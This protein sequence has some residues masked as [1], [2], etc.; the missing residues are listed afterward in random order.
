MIR[1][2]ATTKRKLDSDKKKYIYGAGDVAREV[3]FCLSR[4]PYCISIDAF[5]LTETSTDE[6]QKIEGIPVI[7]ISE[8]SIDKDALIIVAVLEKYRDEICHKLDDMGLQDRIL[9]TFESDIYSELRE[10]SFRNYCKQ[11]GYSYFFSKDEIS[12][13]KTCSANQDDFSVYITRSSKDKILKTTYA[14]K[15]WEK[16]IFA[17]VAL[18]DAGN[19][20]IADDKGD[21]ISIKNRQYCELTVMYWIWKNTDSEYIG[22]SHYRRRF[23]FEDDDIALIKDRHIDCVLTIPMVNVPDVRYMYG[24]NHDINDWEVMVDIVEK[25]YPDYLQSLSVVEKSNY[26]VPYNMFVMRRK[27]FNDYCEWLFPILEKCE[28]KIGQKNDV[29]QNR[30]IGF[31]AER[32]MTMYS[33]YHREDL[34][35]LFWNKHFLE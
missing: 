19:Y 5:I 10:E 9:M 33:Y 13:D 27:V 3:F 35:I 25:I 6:T 30:Y 11:K 34:K 8:R 15:S 28:E 26:Y 1:L 2:L 24:K 20:L 4:E 29:Y 18:D 23:D 12:S 21:N 14:T 17:G 7:S 16:E 22:L 31:L 32:L